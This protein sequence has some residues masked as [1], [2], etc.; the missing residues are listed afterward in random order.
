[1]GLSEHGVQETPLKGA[2]RGDPW[3]E[4]GA[5]RTAGEL[6][7]GKD[8]CPAAGEELALKPGAH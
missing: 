4:I 6:N 5:H 7:T 2:G 8:P 3:K 1:M